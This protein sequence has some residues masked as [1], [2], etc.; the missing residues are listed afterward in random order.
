MGGIYRLTE[1][2]AR[3][4]FVNLLWL[5]CSLFIPLLLLMLLYAFNPEEMP[6]GFYFIPIAAFGAAAPFTMFPATSAMFAVIRKYVQGS[7][8]APV[9]KTFFKGFKENYVKSMWGGL[10][11]VVFFFIIYFNY[12]FYTAPESN[13]RVLGF[14]F[15]FLAVLAVVT[16]FNFFNFIVHLDVKF[17]QLLKNAALMSIGSPLTSIGILLAN[18][19][20]LYLS[21]FQ[22]TFLVPFFTGS[23]M[24]FC[25]Y[26][27][28]DRS[29]NRLLEKT[30]KSEE[31]ESAQHEP[32]ETVGTEK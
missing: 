23:L 14:L 17:G 19:V 16:M 5:A 31:D 20:I 13:L 1:W 25:T 27:L 9:F 29:F 2:I 7:E 18:G 6:E 15:L 11:F 28:Y 10:F 30:R 22:I 3:F 12:H 8:D 26:W 24:A 4:A 32:S 21:Y